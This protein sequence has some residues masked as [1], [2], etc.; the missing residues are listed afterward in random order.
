VTIKL[1]PPARIVR[2]LLRLNRLHATV[3]VRSVGE[4]GTVRW[5]D[6]RIVLVA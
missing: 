2:R 5:R 6:R 4:D 1:R 3:T